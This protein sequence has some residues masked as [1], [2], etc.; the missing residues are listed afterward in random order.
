MRS[1]TTTLWISFL[2]I[3]LSVRYKHQ[4]NKVTIGRAKRVC[5]DK[6]VN[7]VMLA[8][9]VVEMLAGMRLLARDQPEKEDNRSMY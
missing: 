4:T 5:Q 1:G 2:D 6:I 7:W 8:Q 3:L 9:Y